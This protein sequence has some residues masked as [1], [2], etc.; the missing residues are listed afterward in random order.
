MTDSVDYEFIVVLKIKTPNQPKD[1]DPMKGPHVW[2]WQGIFD[3]HRRAH[4]EHN[5]G[6]DRITVE[7]LAPTT[8]GS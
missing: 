7:V 8:M 5:D 2:N 6:P 3:A 1:V 4:G